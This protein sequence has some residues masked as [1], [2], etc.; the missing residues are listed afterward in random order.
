VRFGSGFDFGRVMRAE[1][2]LFPITA[3]ALAGL[4][5]ADPP[6]HGW[7]SRT[8][9]FLLWLFA[10]GSV[11]PILWS[12]GVPLMAA[13]LAT[14][15]VGVVAIVAARRAGRRRAAAGLAPRDSSSRSTG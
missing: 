10:V 11:R 3:I 6:M 5:R 12:L 1:A 15:G 4:R 7:P 14:A 9:L 13:N 2:L 8:R